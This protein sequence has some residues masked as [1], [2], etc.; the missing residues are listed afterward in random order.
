MKRHSIT[1]TFL[2]LLLCGAAFAQSASTK[3]EDEKAIR[4][5]VE[6]IVKGW[7]MKSGEE[8]AKPFAENSDYVV[9]NGTHLKGRAANAV[10]HQQIFDTIYKDQDIAATVE[11]IRFL[12]PDV[13]VGFMHSSYIPLGL[14]LLGTGIPLVA[15]EHISYD[16]YRDRPLQAALLRLTPRLARVTTVLS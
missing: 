2:F 16:H 10:A 13:A 8:L 11:K 1:M 9:I 14:A 6:Q 5:N 3:G 4:A 7:N 12:R 15:S